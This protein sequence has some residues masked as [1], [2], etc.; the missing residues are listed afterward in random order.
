MHPESPSI[1][2]AAIKTKLAALFKVKE[3]A[4]AVF[5]MKIKF[6]GGRS[7]GYALVYD[8]VDMRK[9]YDSKKML[10]RDGYVPKPARTRKQKKEIKGRQ[11]KVRGKAKAAAVNAQKK[12]GKR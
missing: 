12:K 4:V 2:K 3:E 1:S 6:G 11:K 9:K 8:N 10:K 7:S 5:G